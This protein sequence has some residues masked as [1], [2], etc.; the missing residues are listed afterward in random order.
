MLLA[1]WGRIGI[2]VSTANHTYDLATSEALRSASGEYYVGGRVARPP[3][4]AEDAQL[5]ERL[6]RIWEQQTGATFANL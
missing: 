6:W 4:V 5:Q 1:G 2:D 3:S